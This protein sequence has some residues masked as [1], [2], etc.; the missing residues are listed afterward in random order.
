MFARPAARPTP[1][2]TRAGYRKDSTGKWQGLPFK[3]WS[4]ARLTQDV[5]WNGPFKEGDIVCL[6]DVGPGR[7]T[8]N[9]EAG[10]DSEWTKSNA[11]TEYRVV[12]WVRSG[13]TVKGLYPCADRKDAISQ[14]H[15]STQRGGTFHDEIHVD[16]DSVYLIPSTAKNP[17]P[18]Y[19]V[20]YPPP[21]G[22]S[23]KIPGNACGRVLGL[24]SMTS[25][26]EAYTKTHSRAPSRAATVVPGSRAPSRVAG[27]RPASRAGGPTTDSRTL[28]PIVTVERQVY[29]VAFPVEVT[30][31]NRVKCAVA[32]NTA[33]LQRLSAEENARQETLIS[34]R[35]P[36]PKVAILTAQEVGDLSVMFH[37]LQQY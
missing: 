25:G 13:P 12:K 19:I 1:A 2:P 14:K 21:K 6:V 20:K 27:S 32:V 37:P 18:D 7:I 29:V 15:L 26:I 8:P 33:Y 17:I 31:A 28:N 36:E 9:P 30:T 11:D 5:T 22:E 10:Q 34:E 35:L 24:T 4:W 16:G 3:E 23:L